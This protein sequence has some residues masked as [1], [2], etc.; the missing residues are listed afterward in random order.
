MS[1]AFLLLEDSEGVRL[2]NSQIEVEVIENLVEVTVVRNLIKVELVTIPGHMKKQ[3]TKFEA[4]ILKAFRGNRESYEFDVILNKLPY[5]LRD[6]D[7]SVQVKKTEKATANYLDAVI[8]NGTV[9]NDFL[10]GKVVLVINPVVT[11][12]FPSIC[13]FEIKAI[14][15]IDVTDVITIAFGEIHTHEKVNSR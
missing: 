10:N 8:T 15:R 5:D 12:T 14:S 7:V 1:W 3:Y 4:I 2:F 9:G 11:D 6:Y 13:F